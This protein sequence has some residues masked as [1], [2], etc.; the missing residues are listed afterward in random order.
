[1]RSL[2]KDPTTAVSQFAVDI[3][4]AKLDNPLLLTS[5]AVK[6]ISHKMKGR[7]RKR[8]PKGQ[9]SRRPTAYPACIRVAMD[10][11][12]SKVTLKESAILFKM[13]WL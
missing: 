13:G 6:A 10:E 4:L 5:V 8:S 1:M 2:S 9:M 7:R 12:F 3:P 11:A